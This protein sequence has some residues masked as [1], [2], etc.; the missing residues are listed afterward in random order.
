MYH[1]NPPR[2]K[3]PASPAASGKTIITPGKPE[4]SELYRRITTEDTDDKMPLQTGEHA[5]APLSD[6]QIGLIRK[7][8][9]HGAEWEEHWAYLK[10]KKHPVPALN[11]P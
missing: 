11:N 6:A 9:E 7:W 5:D 8:I 1:W 3:P 10:P 4:Q 2:G